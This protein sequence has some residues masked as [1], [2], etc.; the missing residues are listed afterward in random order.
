MGVHHHH[1][2][3]TPP[4]EALEDF[5]WRPG[6]YMPG[7]PSVAETVPSE[8]PVPPVAVTTPDPC[9]YARGLESCFDFR[10]RLASE[11][12][13]PLRVFALNGF[14]GTD[15]GG[16]K[17]DTDGPPRLGVTSIHPCGASG[18]VNMVPAETKYIGL[19]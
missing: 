15:G 7:S 10:I 19:A 17:R 16:A 3:I 14:E 11:R 8:P 6:L 5:K 12:K 13:A 1:P 4:A 9:T 2:E 18:K